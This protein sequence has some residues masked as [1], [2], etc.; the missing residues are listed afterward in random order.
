MIDDKLCTFLNQHTGLQTL[1]VDRIEAY[2]DP[3]S[4]PSIAMLEHL[5]HL[6]IRN[7]S[8]PCL[9][10]ILS[11][12]RAPHL[13]EFVVLNPD[14][15]DQIDE[16]YDYNEMETGFAMEM[17]ECV[18][19]NLGQLVSVWPICIHLLYLHRPFGLR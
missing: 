18:R 16:H 1:I 15:P 11:C 8:R 3:E 13:E 19:R 6:E 4:L 17:R 14:E 2:Y 5:R 7:V 12:L 10:G 9:A